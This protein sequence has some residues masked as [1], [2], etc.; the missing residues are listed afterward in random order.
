MFA[1]SLEEAEVESYNNIM[2]SVAQ[3][4]QTGKINNIIR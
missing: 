1:R 3:Y 2:Q 4:A